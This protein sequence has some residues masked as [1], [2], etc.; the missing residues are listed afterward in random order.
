M[1]PRDK[2]EYVLLRLTFLPFIDPLYPQMSINRRKHS[3][4]TSITQV[5]DWFDRVMSYE[6]SKLPVNTHL[7]YTEWRI[8]T[9]NPNDFIVEGGCKFDKAIIL[10]GEEN[11]YWV[12]YHNFPTHRRYEGNGKINVNF[13]SCCMPK[14]YEK[15][16]D[17]VKKTISKARRPA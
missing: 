15:I 2:V 13:C 12:F 5:R 17:Y 4:S 14:H 7:R 11:A 8:L 16:I 10:V 6:K 1:A 9:G 3:P